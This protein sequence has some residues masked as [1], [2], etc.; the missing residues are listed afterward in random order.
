VKLSELPQ[1]FPFEEPVFGELGLPGGALESF[2]G[3]ANGSPLALNPRR[4]LEGFSDAQVI[5]AI[6]WAVL[7]YTVAA[8]LTDARVRRG[9]VAAILVLGLCTGITNWDTTILSES[10]GISLMVLVIAVWVRWMRRPEPWLSAVLIVLMVLWTFVR[11]D[12]LVITGLVALLAVVAAVR[13][14][15]RAWMV[16]AVALVLLTV[17]GQRTYSQNRELADFNVAQTI[18]DRVIPNASRTAWFVD[19]GMPVPASITVGQ[20]IGNTPGETLLKDPA[21]KTWL[22]DHGLAT[23]ERYLITHPGY[24]LV[25][26]LG[27]MLGTT[28]PTLGSYPRGPS[29][30]GPTD[31]YG[32]GRVVL[33]ILVELMLYAPGD[34]GTVLLALVLVILALANRWRRSGFDRRWTV[35]LTVLV[36][37]IAFL[38]VTWLASSIEVSRHAIDSALTGRIALIVLGALLLDAH[39]RPPA[40]L[41]QNVVGTEGGS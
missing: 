31:A 25:G 35:P 5:A 23:Y 29:M 4:E 27:D 40:D 18:G 10:V 21:F 8:E 41:R 36:L 19:H 12:H 24:A 39:V 26:P 2:K 20:V 30:L 22:H 7:A 37:A 28:V 15:R 38:W 11:Q 16:V 1:D 14:R 13:S 17:W 32:Q 34:G 33:P 9:A 6:A 3:V